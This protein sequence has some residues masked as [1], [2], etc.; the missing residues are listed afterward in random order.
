MHAEFVRRF[1]Q[2]DPPTPESLGNWKCCDECRERCRRL[3]ATDLDEPED[4]VIS[5]E[6]GMGLDAYRFILPSQVYL[7]LSNPEENM[8]ELTSHFHHANYRT[9]S[10][11][12]LEACELILDYCRS[13][14]YGTDVEQARVSEH[15]HNLAALRETGRL[16]W[17]EA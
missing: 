1:G 2:T 16:P 13:S 5:Y 15:L 8:E 17:E 6:G 9:F 12:E 14:G 4:G 3:S 7:A 10:P 11:E